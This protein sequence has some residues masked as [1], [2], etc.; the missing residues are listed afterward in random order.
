MKFEEYWSLMKSDLISEKQLHT[1]KQRK[2]FIARYWGGYVE[3][4][5]PTITAPR[6]ILQKEFLQVWESAKN[7]NK[8]EQLVTKNYLDITQNASYILAL[9][10]YYLKGDSID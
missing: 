7:Y 4:T 3:T 5:S 10:N 1:M 2:A 9:M 6:K 8:G